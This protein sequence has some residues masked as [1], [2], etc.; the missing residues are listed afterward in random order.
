MSLKSLVSKYGA[1]RVSDTI[2][3]LNKMKKNTISHFRTELREVD[4]LG[5]VVQTFQNMTVLPGRVAVLEDIFKTNFVA[6]HHLF[7][8]DLYT[9]DMQGGS[10]MNPTAADLQERKVCAFVMGN[11]GEHTAS[12]LNLY[13]THSYESVLYNRYLP[14]RFVPIGQDLSAEERANY[15]LREIVDYGGDDYIAYYAKIFDPG[16]VGLIKNDLDYTITEGDSVPVDPDDPESHPLAGFSIDSFVEFELKA[17]GLDLKEKYKLDHDGSLADNKVTETGLVLG[18][19]KQVTGSDGVTY[20]ELCFSE[21]FAKVTHSPAYL[22]SE[23]AQRSLM[24]K[25]FS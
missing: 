14:M 1:E 25:I 12:P 17:D 23:G 6:G 15:R 22:D 11:G 9:D 18:V 24:Y 3:Y 2:E 5:Q 8:N 16:Q 19:D 7:L 4:E 20:T 13:K 10:S 21:L